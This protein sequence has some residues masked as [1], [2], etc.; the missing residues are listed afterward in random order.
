MGQRKQYT[1]EFKREALELA[2]TSDKSAAQIER[3][4]GLYPGQL[5]AWKR[6]FKHDGEQAFPGSGHL[7]AS[8][9]EL[10]RLRRQIEVLETER[11]ILKKAVAIFAHPK[12]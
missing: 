10:Q 8:E 11:E 3:D 4:F 6:Q 7:K 12:G 2:K 5:H 9:A 1:R